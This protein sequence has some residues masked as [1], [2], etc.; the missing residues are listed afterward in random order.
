[1]VKAGDYFGTVGSGFGETVAIYCE[2]KNP[3]D[4]LGAFAGNPSLNSTA[5]LMGEEPGFQNP[6]VVFVEPDA[7]SDGY[8]D[9]TQ[10]KCPQSAAFQAECPTVTVDANASARKSSVTVLVTTSNSAPVTVVGAVKL[11]KGKSAK[12]TAKAQTVSPGKLG[13]FTLKF[14]AK[15]K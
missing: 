14:P 5:S 8:G 7:D 3:G 2:T 4:R 15:L 10:D 12:L 13:R 6:I 11:G 9:E 1:P